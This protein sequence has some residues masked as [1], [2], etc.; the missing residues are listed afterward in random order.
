MS[1]FVAPIDVPAP[2]PGAFGQCECGHRIYTH[3]RLGKDGNQVW[4]GCNTTDCPCTTYHASDGSQWPNTHSG[5]V[6][7]EPAD[8]DRNSDHWIDGQ[9]YLTDD[10]PPL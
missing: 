8:L 7:P 9:V 1:A 6:P 2:A 4:M 10:E 3:G 5:P